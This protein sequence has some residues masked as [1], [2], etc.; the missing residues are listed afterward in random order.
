[1]HRIGVELLL[2][3]LR[4]AVKAEGMDSIADE[5]RAGPADMD[6][7]MAD[8]IGNEGDTVWARLLSAV[9]LQIQQLFE[10]F[11][12][13]VSEVFF[14]YAKIHLLHHLL[15]PYI[16]FICALSNYY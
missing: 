16:L 1:M 14:L 3:V 9:Q 15:T 6:T 4:R 11:P 8:S 10:A 2:E 13:S 7:G 5:I 12:I